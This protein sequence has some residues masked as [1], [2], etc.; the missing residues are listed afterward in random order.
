MGSLLAALTISS[1]VFVGVEAL[2]IQPLPLTYSQCLN[3]GGLPLSVEAMTA[4]IQP[5]VCHFTCLLEKLSR[6]TSEG[7]VM[8]STLSKIKSTQPKVDSGPVKVVEKKV[9]QS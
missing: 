8:G 4:D 1:P 3:H 6:E 9:T 7:C 2:A 5:V